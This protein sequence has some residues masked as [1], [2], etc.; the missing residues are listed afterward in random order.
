MQHKKIRVGIVFG[1]RSAEHEVSV[2]SAHSIV[3]ALDK[4]KFEPILIGITKEGG[5]EFGIKSFL[6]YKNDC[7]TASS[8]NG[9]FR[10]NTPAALEFVPQ[11]RNIDKLDVI[12]PVLHGPYGEDGSI[13]GLLKL[14]GIPFIG[15]D[16]LGSAIGMDKDVMKRLL[17]QG[18]IPITKYC[19]IQ[20]RELKEV[21]YPKLKNN[22]VK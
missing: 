6:L 21:S 3:E 20:R 8:L 11:Q 19:V 15:S 2:R 7:Q 17:K 13:Q 14:T 12:F 4:N 1:G 10:K 9:N 18:E 16:I 22:L 5:W